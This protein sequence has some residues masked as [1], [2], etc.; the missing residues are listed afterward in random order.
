[1][2]MKLWISHSEDPRRETCPQPAFLK[3]IVLQKESVYFATSPRNDYRF[4]EQRLSDVGHSVSRRVTVPSFEQLG[5]PGLAQEDAHVFIW[6]LAGLRS[7]TGTQA[8]GGV[9]AAT[10][11]SCLVAL[12]SSRSAPVGAGGCGEPSAMSRRRVGDS[13]SP[14]G[15]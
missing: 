3:K 4:Q 7:H 12:P 11:L 5:T 2:R 15:V 14:G 1:M 9:T 6:W 13:V 10:S 8:P